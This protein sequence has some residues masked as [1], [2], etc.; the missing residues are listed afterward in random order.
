M[1]FEGFR[2]TY[3]QWSFRGFEAAKGAPPK[4]DKGAEGAEVAEGEG[5][6]GT[7]ARKVPM[8]KGAEGTKRCY[9]V[10]EAQNLF[11]VLKALLSDD[12]RTPDGQQIRAAEIPRHIKRGIHV[13][14]EL[15][16]YLLPFPR[17]PRSQTHQKRYTYII[18]QLYIYIYVYLFQGC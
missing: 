7:H 2:T 15:C 6:E 9:L 8:V 18:R 1:D 12:V 11:K 5:A 16:V 14:R 10:L 4:G 17:L 13:I 3:A